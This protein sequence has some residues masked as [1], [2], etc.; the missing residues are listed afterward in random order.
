L[1]LS[2]ALASPAFILGYPLLVAALQVLVQEYFESRRRQPAPHTRSSAPRRRPVWAQPHQAAVTGDPVALREIAGER[3]QTRREIRRARKAAKRTGMASAPADP[4][5]RDTSSGEDFL[6]LILAAGAGLAVAA[7]YLTARAPIQLALLTL[8]GLT[9]GWLLAVARR[10][11]RR[12][13]IASDWLPLFIASSALFL[14][15]FVC[16]WQLRDPLF[17]GA[18]TR[19]GEGLAAY[20]RGGFRGVIDEGGLEAVMFFALQGFAVIFV[21]VAFYRVVRQLIGLRWEVADRRGQPVRG[22]RGRLLDDDR[23]SGVSPWS[24]VGFGFAGVGLALVLASGAAAAGIQAAQPKPAHFVELRVGAA[25]GAI[26]IQGKIEPEVIATTDLAIRIR[27]GGVTLRTLRRAVGA[28]PFTYSIATDR[29]GRPLR[30]GRYRVLLSLDGRS[31]GARDVR[32]PR[33]RSG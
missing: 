23:D 8:T 1:A 13:A 2:N 18:D 15:G 27:K 6:P 17:A 32:I 29:R 5:S 26:L 3:E 31:A 4:S 9:L 28:Q 25:R 30:P 19:Y 7:G 12:S 11:R 14:L 21:V 33:R 16:V 24:G 10:M 22:W 20:E